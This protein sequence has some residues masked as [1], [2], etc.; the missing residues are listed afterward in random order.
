[1]KVAHYTLHLTYFNIWRGGPPGWR[2]T[3]WH[4]ASARQPGDPVRPCFEF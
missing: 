4:L 1:V 2:T 3:A